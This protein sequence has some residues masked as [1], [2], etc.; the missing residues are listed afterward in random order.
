MSCMKPRDTQAGRSPR[1]RTPCGQRVRSRGE[2]TKGAQRGAPMVW[3]LKKSGGG[4]VMVA[5]GRLLA[6]T[7]NRLPGGLLRQVLGLGLNTQRL[8]HGVIEELFDVPLAH[9]VVPSF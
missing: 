1:A 4:A 5:V 8:G 9:P 7:L 3:A 6:R 2:T